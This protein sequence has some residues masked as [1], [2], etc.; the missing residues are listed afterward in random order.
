MFNISKQKNF[1]TLL[2]SAAAFNI[3]EVFVID[4]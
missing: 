2:R 1:G 3:S 4:G